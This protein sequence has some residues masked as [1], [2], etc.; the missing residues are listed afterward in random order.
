MHV[1]TVIAVTI[2]HLKHFWVVLYF[3]YFNFGVEIIQIQ[4]DP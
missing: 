2:L 1:F 3:M 4:S